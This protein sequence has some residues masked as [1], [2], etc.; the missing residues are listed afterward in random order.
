[1]ETTKRIAIYNQNCTQAGQR[2]WDA[3]EE[4]DSRDVQWYDASDLQW[5]TECLGVEAKNSN[6]LFMH[7]VAC[8]IVR[9]FANA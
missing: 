4:D 1:M 6:D 9:E 8:E 7:S 5:A 3:D 2:A